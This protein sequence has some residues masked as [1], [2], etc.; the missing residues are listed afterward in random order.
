MITITTNNRKKHQWH[1]II[2]KRE[3]NEALVLREIILLLFIVIDLKAY[4]FVRTII[5][6]F[7]VRFTE[8]SFPSSYDLVQLFKNAHDN[9]SGNLK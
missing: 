4:E 5:R 3:Y 8:T 6:V 2:N 7:I 9:V 1:F